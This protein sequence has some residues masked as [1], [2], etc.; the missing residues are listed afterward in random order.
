MATLKGSEVIGIPLEAA[1]SKPK[2]VDK[3]WWETNTGVF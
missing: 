3:K 2:V 1:V